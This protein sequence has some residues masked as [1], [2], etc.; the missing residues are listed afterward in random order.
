[1]P[2][3]PTEELTCTILESFQIF[4]FCVKSPTKAVDSLLQCTILHSDARAIVQ[5]TRD[6]NAAHTAAANRKGGQQESRN[7]ALGCVTNDRQIIN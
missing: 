6:M 4:C 5:A 1:M 7:I 3:S 2:W